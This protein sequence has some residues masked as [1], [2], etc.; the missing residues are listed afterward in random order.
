MAPTLPKSRSNLVYDRERPASASRDSSLTERTVGDEC[1][2][3]PLTIRQNLLLH[4]S[5]YKAVFYLVRHNLFPRQ[6]SL[7]IPHLSDREIADTDVPHHL[8]QH[9]LLHSLHGLS[10]RSPRIRPVKLVEVHLLQS[11]PFK[12]LPRGPENIVIPEVRRRDF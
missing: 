8:V 9:E 1:E 2:L 5:I 12:A 11:Q 3:L 4:C 6:R 10:N 7:R